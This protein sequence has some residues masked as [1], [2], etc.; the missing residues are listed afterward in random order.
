MKNY[1]DRY[2]AKVRSLVIPKN[3]IDTL[4]NNGMALQIVTNTAVYEVPAKA[5][6]N[7]ASQYGA[8]DKVIF[9]ISKL[10]PLD[11]MLYDRAYPEIFI[12]GEN[13]E[14]SLRGESKNARI[15]KLDESMKIKQKLQLIGS[16]NFENVNAYMYNPNTATW[17]RPN[18]V[19]ET[20]QDI[21]YSYF[22]YSTYNTGSHVLYQTLQSQEASSS[23]YIMN[24]LKAKYNIRGLGDIYKSNDVVYADQYIKL[25]MGIAKKENQ[26]TLNQAPTQELKT[27]AKTSG[28]YTSYNTG[29]ITNEQAIAGVVRLYELNAGYKVKPSKVNISGVSGSYTESV[30]KA[31]AIGLIDASFKGYSKI[32]YSELC[33]LIIQVVE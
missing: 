29:T 16:Y 26:I 12:K 9:N 11:I 17:W 10:T 32:T 30:G 31:Y 20:T 23:T 27:Q 22:M 4:D 14:V 6:R 1:K 19:K 28:I 3:V 15:I 7:Q 2:D 24:E 33:D 21:E 13:F 25:M 18:A 8:R 5:L